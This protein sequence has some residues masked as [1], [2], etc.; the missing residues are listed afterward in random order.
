[1]IGLWRNDA[2][3]TG[4]FISSNGGIPQ[5]LEWKLFIERDIM[6]SPIAVKNVLFISSFA[7]RRS[8][9]NGYLFLVDLPKRSIRRWRPKA[10]YEPAIAGDKIVV[11][12]VEFREKGS[13]GRLVCYDLS[14]QSEVWRHEKLFGFVFSPLI[15]GNRVFVAD[16]NSVKSFRLSDGIPL[17][18][19]VT[20][21]A[22]MG[23]ALS[24]GLVVVNTFRVGL[25]AYDAGTGRLKWHTPLP[26]D[27]LSL[28]T[29]CICGGNVFVVLKRESAFTGFVSC[30][31][32]KSGRLAWRRE[33]ADAGDASPAC[34]GKQIYIVELQGIVS[35]L[36]ISDG[37][38][39]WTTRL[40][41]GSSCSPSVAG[42]YLYLGDRE[43]HLYAIDTRSGKIVWRYRTQ[44]QVTGSP[45]LW[46]NQILFASADG[47]VYS[48]G[49]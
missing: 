20:G 9:K 42:S 4:H 33:I 14:L 44:G 47:Y 21:G 40:E 31:D 46:K 43:G 39:R 17:W 27:S 38:I 36:R 32:L 37:N 8:Q 49:L 18:S 45:W 3:R 48:F 22:S 29:P 10:D 7:K 25:F 16:W 41:G 30:F 6:G 23:L 26:E 2:R 35:C 11:F 5:S 12:V 13:S 1:M 34:D 19:S 28:S 15:D 24:S